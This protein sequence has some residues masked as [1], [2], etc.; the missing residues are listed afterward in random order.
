[1]ALSK[2]DQKTL[3]YILFLVLGFVI[4]SFGIEPI[5]TSYQQ[6]TEDLESEQAKY[7]QNQETLAEG[8]SIDEGY[9]RVEGQFPKEDPDRDPSEVFSEEVVNLIEKQTGNIPGY[10]PPTSLE[11][12]GATGYEFLIMPIN[13]KTT[14][15]KVAGVLK[16]FE[17]KGYL[18]QT[19]KINRETDL[20]K[21][22][23]TVD[24]N[25]GRIVK[26][27]TEEEQA[28]QDGPAAPGSL[29]LNRRGA[30]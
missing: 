17:T 24:L 6:L 29:K 25:L 30:R 18:I 12:K 16:E 20:N 14:L 22:E 11:I 27:V 3:S 19:A 2:R 1:M 28:A 26:I 5:W 23:L 8:K 10:S 21:E 13:L 7:E 4:W 15:D 9:R